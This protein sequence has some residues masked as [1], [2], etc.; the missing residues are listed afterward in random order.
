MKKIFL[1]TFVF[2]LAAP[3]LAQTG[4]KMS[5]DIKG[6]DVV[7]VLKILASKSGRNLVLDKNVSGRVTVFLKDVDPALALDV[8]LK[9]N[10][11]VAEEEGSITRITTNA[12]YQARHGESVFDPREIRRVGL[13]HAKPEVLLPLL[14]Q[15]KSRLGQVSSDDASQSIVL[16]DTPKKNVEM[17]QMIRALDQ[18][19]EILVLKLNY[20]RCEKVA[21]LLQDV[22]TKTIGSVKIDSRSNQLIVTDVRQNLEKIKSLVQ[23]L[24]ER[25]KEVRID[26]KIVQ[27]V[28]DHKTSLGIDWNYVLNQK[29]RAQGA[30]GDVISTA[31]NKWTFATTSLK[32]A[33]DY[34]V[35]LEALET[36]GD[37]KILSS[38]HLTV[39][40]N[41][42]AK[43]LVGSKQVYVT[44]S[45]VQSQ[46]TTETAEA[47]N[48]VDVGVKLFVT[49]S[50]GHDGYISL[51]IRPEVSSVVQNYKTVSGN[52]IPI[53]ETSEAETT[54]LLR[55]GETAVIA[56]L[57]KEEKIKTVRK[58]PLF[59]DIPLLGYF[60]RNSEDS[61]QKTELVVF[62]SCHLV[63]YPS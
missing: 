26:A 34:Q 36:Q 9:A 1:F 63:E 25:T 12:D 50:I 39:A 22:L 10:G 2:L 37:T 30:F 23:S 38:P 6:M 24:D 58:I 3:L 7:D 59:G 43:I 33:N 32:D 48:F 31:G 49:P 42:S 5:L 51:K 55:D 17:L 41:E 11:L 20:A 54:V 15:M 21:E 57:I 4:E 27:V 8:I 29:I 53:V 52:T 28:L 13:R 60:F 35:V 44:T 14:N 18:P 40:N 56:G 45:A 61:S 47:V 62:L 16:M 19:T 46:T